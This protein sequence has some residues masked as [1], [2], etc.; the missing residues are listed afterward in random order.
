ML[1]DSMA[2]LYL[3][4]LGCSDAR[5]VCKENLFRLQE[6]HLGKIPYTNLSFFRNGIVTSLETEA[7]FERLIIQKKGG[8][9]FELNGL[10]SKLL[11]YLGYD[12]TDFFGRWHFGSAEAIPMR[13]HRILKVV[14][15]DET[16]LADA[17]IGSLCP[18]TPLVFKHDII[19]QKNFRS[20]RIVKDPQ[21]GNVVQA[22]TPEGFLPY[23]SFT[24]DPHFP[25]DFVY[26]H[27]YC[28]QQPDSIFRN[29]LFLHKITAEQ[30]QMIVS[31]TPDSSVWGV[32]TR[33]CQKEELHTLHT[34][35]EMLKLITEV[36]GLNYTA[37]D[38]PEISCHS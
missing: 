16:F 7:L 2:K 5:A 6:A 12:V 15:G 14:L 29:K 30:Q 23:F 20:Y 3:E 28:I 24:E 31:P 11:R 36:F 9:C 27:T 38:L 1:T 17:G 4:V 19:Q 21:L 34:K 22:E 26:V 37:A 10:F 33:E 8:Y 35:E 13:R 32:L 18:V 25:Q